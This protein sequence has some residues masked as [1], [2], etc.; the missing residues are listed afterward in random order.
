MNYTQKQKVRDRVSQGYN[1]EL[2]DENYEYIPAKKKA[3][4]YDNDVPQRV[5]IYVRV[6]T[7]D[8]SQTTSYELQRKYYED[9]VAHHPCW[10][11]V[12]IYPDEG[13]S[14]TSLKHRDGFNRMIADCRAGKIDL[15]ITKSVSRFARNVMHCIGTVQE[16]RNM[17]PPVGVFF[18]SE[19]I[20]SLNDESQISLT[21]QATIAQEESHLKSRSM[22]TSLGMR[23]NHGLPLTPHLLGYRKDAESGKLRICE[24]EAPT[25]KL[26][27]YMY[28]YGYS[29]QE[30]ADTFIK[31]GKK[32]RL[33]N[34][35][36]TSGGILQILRS[37]RYCGDVKTRK[38]FTP[39]YLTH[40]SRKN[41]GERAQSRYLNWHEPIVSR[42]DFLAVQRMID[43]AKY[44]NKTILPT[45]Q[46]IAEGLLKGFVT[47][48]P[49]WAGFTPEEFFC[50]SESVYLPDEEAECDGEQNVEDIDSTDD[51][52]IQITIEAG[53]F[54]MRGFHVVPGDY[55]DSFR[56]ACAVFSDNKIQFSTECIRKFDKNPYVELLIHPKGKWLAVRPTTKENRNGI[57]WSRLVTG[58]ACPKHISAAAFYN[59]LCSILDWNPTV[60]YRMQ[61]TLI[62]NGDEQ[63]Y[64]FSAS[65]PE[66]FL[67]AY[68]VP[69]GA[70][71]VKPLIISG[72]YVRVIPAQWAES[73]GRLYYDKSGD[74][75][76]SSELSRENWMIRMEG[77]QYETGKRL[78]VTPYEELEAYIKQELG[79][80]WHNEEEV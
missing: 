1:V 45:L 12:G 51:S 22:E 40:K 23:L 55:F 72:K 66:T 68:L 49:R 75:P 3:D 52:D 73:F 18:Q 71:N 39:D 41:R 16:L 70:D 32:S 76:I 67:K 59:T 35:K 31:L 47:V 30:I 57:V 80:L 19:A 61:G 4:Y 74:L 9:F 79:A 63:V 46:V 8:V 78:C 6:S 28:L 62:R 50:A 64:I 17:Y 34:C 77:Q 69:G 27:F 26:A 56:S 48:N 14:G 38:T 65:N 54:D 11:L 25:A 60:K 5:A 36:W 13:I 53:D 42:D 37:E 10:T 7:D 21:F 24:E 2:N 29:T 58:E 44:G 15:I 20:F 43:N 33:G